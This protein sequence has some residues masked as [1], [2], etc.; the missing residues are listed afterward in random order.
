MTALGVQATPTPRGDAM[1][2][3]SARHCA[4]FVLSLEAEELIP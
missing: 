2:V 3:A 1:I 4:D